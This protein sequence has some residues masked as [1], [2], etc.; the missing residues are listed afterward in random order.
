MFELLETSPVPVVADAEYRRLLGFPSAHEPGERAEELARGARD[1]YAVH[2]RPWLYLREVAFEFPG[3]GETLRLDGVEFDSPKLREHLRSVNATRALVVLVS[4]GAACEEQARRLWEDEKPDEYFFLEVF[5]SAVV[6]QLVASVSGRICD[7]AERDGLIA[8]PHYSPGYVGWDIADQ[9][10]LFE[11]LAAR[12]TQPLP[13]TLSVLAS[14]MLKPKKSLLAVFGLTPRPANVRE[15]ARLVPC[16][17]CSLQPCQ[18]RR[19][20]YHRA[21]LQV[22]SLERPRRRATGEVPTVAPE[23]PRAPLTVNARYS[24]NPRALEK[25]AK[26][27]VRLSFHDDRSVDATFRFDGTTCSNMGQP[28]AFEYRVALGGPRVRYP[29]LTAE[30]RPV[31]G[32]VGHTRMCAYL[33]APAEL[34]AAIAVEGPLLGR[35]L[36]DVVSWERPSRSAGCY[37]D[38]D[39]RL[40]KWGMALE[41]IH[42]ALVRA[43][44]AAVD[45]LAARAAA[46]TATSASA[47]NGSPSLS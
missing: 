47:A 11:L 28:L 44:G 14:G 31:E 34:M 32:D 1:W 29:I 36:D 25:W 39:S 38:R 42:F 23:A 3:A 33:E 37:C 35:P 16:E 9:S 7:L 21:P 8:T 20:A 46:A 22:G 17:S 41:V 5:G 27:R 4:A 40:H 15:L 19:A 10:R 2:G 45:R 43:G 24:L 6:E 30:C 26:E 13:E 12:L 18:Y